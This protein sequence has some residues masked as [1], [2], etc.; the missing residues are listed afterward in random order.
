MTRPRLPWLLI[1]ALWVAE[2]A[3]SFESAMILAALK[4]LIA[5]FRDPVLVG[6]LV[7]GFLIVGAAAAALVG[8][9]GDLFGR[10]R[11]LLI[12]LA[13]GAAGSLLSWI[14]SNYA[15]LLTG[16]IMQGVTGTILALCIGLVRENLPE[17]RVPMGIGLM[18]SGASLGTAA[19][20]VVGGAIVDQ[21]SW[22]GIFL[23]SAGFCLVAL[24]LVRAF[25][26]V[27]RTQ[28]PGAPVDWLSGILFAPGVILVL[29]YLS[30][31]KSWGWGSPAALGF[32]AAG[33]A[34]CGWW[35]RQSLRSANPLIDV[36]VLGNRA[37]AVS[38]AASALVAMGTLQ[39]TVFF[40]L[41]LQAPLWTGAGLG[42]TATL[43]GLAK[44]PSNL[45][46]VFAGPL[47]GWMTGR[48]GGR[49]ALV[50]GAAVTTLGWV[51]VFLD[52]SSVAIV[53]GELIVISFGATMLFAVAPTIIAGAAPPDRTSEVSGMLGVIRSLFL[54]I[55]SQLVATLLA[56]DS[57][58]RGRETYPS[59]F[60]YQLAVG[61]II[62]LSVAAM[63]VSL[64]IP[65]GNK[66]AWE[67]QRAPST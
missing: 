30:N 28:P 50:A 42:L 65:A 10:R 43:A 33:I 14:S 4:V 57:V 16:R 22:H 58:T 1:G 40:S 27:S 59:P 67:K 52:T 18:I 7:T 45:T 20:L 53:V 21:F 24:V 11:V 13:I 60:A 25:V 47:G 63:L 38:C 51:L 23:A 64:A 15:V 9:L 5:E 3:S 8:R 56:V 46:S 32:L 48:G 36:R 54:G 17:E 12:V 61:V 35:L 2:M 41:L 55:G 44:L 29:L 19:G 26:P 66:A 37:I 34:L 49:L 39:I 6:W 31:G 62:A